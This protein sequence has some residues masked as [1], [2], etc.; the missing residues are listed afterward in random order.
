MDAIIEQF[1]KAIGQI[2]TKIGTWFTDI[3]T[4]L[5]N[6]VL[7]IIVFVLA[8]FAAKKVKE[9]T[10]R[11]LQRLVS[12]ASVRS[13][14]SNV[15]AAIVVGIGLILAL[16]VLNLEGMLTSL[17]AGAGIAGLA[18][19]LAL[20]GTLSNMFSGIYLAVKDVINIGD[21]IET[22][23]YAGTVVEITLRSTQIKESDNNI[24]VIPNKD[25]MDN[26]FKNYALTKRLRITLSCGVG[27]ESDL[28]EVRDIAQKAIGDLFKPHEG[29]KVEFHY[30]EF[31]D[32]SINFQVRFWVDAKLSLTVLEARSEA[33][34]ALKK[35][36]DA[37]DIN[38]PFPIRTLMHETPLKLEKT[39]WE[40]REELMETENSKEG[41]DSKESK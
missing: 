19:S 15:S 34:I 18:I 9:Y 2:K 26:P 41:K 14:I 33:V 30:L 6:L 20:Q 27:Y 24:V 23:G 10:A 7:A 37:K 35:A 5:P 12:Q 31:G 40:T 1:N 3:I 32:S 4:A 22:N 25:V 39:G 36:F 38:I 13:L 28:E 21:W 11:G 16:N 17:L 8:Y 29:E